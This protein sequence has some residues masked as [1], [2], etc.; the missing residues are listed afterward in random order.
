MK[1]FYLFVALVIGVL[2]GLISCARAPGPASTASPV[3]SPAA[4][5]ISPGPPDAEGIQRFES[6]WAEVVPEN[7]TPTEYNIPHSLDNTQKFIDLYGSIELTA[8]EQ[9]IRDEALTPLVAPCCD[10]F[11]MKTCCCECNLARSVWGLTGYLVANDYGTGQVREAASQWLHFVRPDY[12]VAAEL[13]QE[14]IEPDRFGV[15]LDSSCFNDRCDTPFYT[16]DS[17]K[18]LGGCGGMK[19]LI[20]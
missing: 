8:D 9:A 2:F 12:Y 3:S 4:T 1:L 20:L 6:I 17:S 7:G 11:S 19:D 5:P 16:K 14:G 13:Q 15:S 10:D 18:H